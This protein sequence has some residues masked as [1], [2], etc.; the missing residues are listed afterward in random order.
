M[1]EMWISMQLVLAVMPI[2]ATAVLGLP[3]TDDKAKALRQI[4]AIAMAWRIEREIGS[5]SG[6][7]I[8]LVISLGRDVI[9][10]LSKERRAKTAARSGTIG[11]DN[12]LG[13]LRYLRINKAILQTDKDSFRGAEAK[14]IVALLKSPGEFALEWAKRPNYAKRPGLYGTGDFA[15]K[16]A[17]CERWMKGTRV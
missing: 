3:D 16:A 5:E 14:E 17:E 4:D 10:R 7:R 1:A 13:S 8:C 9:A 6:D 12:H 11:F 2:V 15:A